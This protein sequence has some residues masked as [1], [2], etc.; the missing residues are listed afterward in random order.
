VN[1]LIVKLSAIGDVLHTLPAVNAMRRRWPGAHIAWIVEAAASDLLRGHPAVD[2][3]LVSYRRQWLRDLTTRRWL[4]GVRGAYR[5]IKALRDTRYDLI[6]DFQALLKSAIWIALARGDRKVGFGRGM[7]HM[8]HSYLFLNERVPPVSMNIHALKRNLMLVAALGIPAARIE[9]RLPMGLRERRAVDRLLSRV[10]VDGGEALVAV[11]PVAKWATKL[12]P[13]HRFSELADALHHEFGYRPVFTG[14]AADRPAIDRILSQAAAGI[15]LAGRTGLIELA[16]LYRRSAVVVSTDTG[17]MH[18]AAA[19]GTPVVALFGPTAPWRTG[20]FGRGHRVVRSEPPCSPCF[21]RRC[22]RPV[23]MTAISVAQVRAAI[24]ALTDS[25][26]DG[27][28]MAAVRSVN[29]CANGD[30]PPCP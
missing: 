10:G 26:P 17:P 3:V 22:E 23:C 4:R 15:N 19:V 28:A 9:Y 24:A 8:E 1:I 27:A 6:I 7:E 21:K 12:W 20:P 5:F 11:N 29:A 18:L 25:V 13:E 16:E 14:S 2:R 30:R